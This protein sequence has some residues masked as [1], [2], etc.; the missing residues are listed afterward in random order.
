MCVSC[1]GGGRVFFGFSFIPFSVS[2]VWHS[3]GFGREIGK[4]LM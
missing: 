1:F 2:A 3:V 4:G